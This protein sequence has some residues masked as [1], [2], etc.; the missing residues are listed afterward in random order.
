MKCVKFL[1]LIANTVILLICLYISVHDK[2]FSCRFSALISPIIEFRN[3]KLYY[4]KNKAL[5]YTLTYIT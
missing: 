5:Q 2:S 3:V 1:N 4:T